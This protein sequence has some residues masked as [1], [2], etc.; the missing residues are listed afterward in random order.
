MS[1]AIIVESTHL[2]FRILNAKKSNSLIILTIL[3]SLTLS[4]KLIRDCTFWVIRLCS[5]GN[6]GFRLT[7]EIS[8]FVLD[9]W[10]RVP[11]PLSHIVLALEHRGFSL[12]WIK[13]KNNYF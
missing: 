13:P 8:K 10:F 11:Q 7:G 5:V 6:W 12:L 2:Q 9:F 3:N 1:D 4:E